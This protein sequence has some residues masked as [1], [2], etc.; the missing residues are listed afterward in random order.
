MRQI[1]Q[2]YKRDTKPYIDG[3]ESDIRHS[4]NPTQRPAIHNK[5]RKKTTTTTT[6]TSQQQ[7]K[8]Q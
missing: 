3:G 7:Q 8:Q 5:K 2:P 6:T 1:T 4:K